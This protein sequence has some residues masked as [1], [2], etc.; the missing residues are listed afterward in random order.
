MVRGCSPRARRGDSSIAFDGIRVSCAVTVD[1]AS[2]R[3]RRC[4]RGGGGRIEITVPLKAY[5]YVVY[6]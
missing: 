3:M 4:K 5:G 2:W 1:D 6:F